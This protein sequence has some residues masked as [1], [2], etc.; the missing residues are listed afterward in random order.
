LVLLAA[1]GG[2]VFVER[3]SRQSAAAAALRIQELLAAGVTVLVFPEGTSSDGATVLPFYPSLLEPAIRL[4]APITSAAIGY[5]A[6]EAREEELCYYGDI[7]FAPHL[8]LT[9]QLPE[10]LATLHFAPQGRIYR[11]RKQAAVET[12]LEVE[13]LRNPVAAGQEV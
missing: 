13:A 8:F 2:T 10:V 5:S 12:R 9:L 7:T 11:D 4:K 3:K 1:L 6:G